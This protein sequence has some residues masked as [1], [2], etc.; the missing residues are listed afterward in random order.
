MTN[1]YKEDLNAKTTTFFPLI[2]FPYIS[3]EMVLELKKIAKEKRETARICLH[4]SSDSLLQFMLIFHPE[5]KKINI[6]KFLQQDSIYMLIEGEF[7]I[8]ML[9]ENLS[10]LQKI[11]FSQT[12]NQ[13]FFIPKNNFYKLEIISQELLLAEVRTGPFNYAN[14][15]IIKD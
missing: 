14:Q 15:I 2:N 1:V 5:R 9:D 7:S 10:V 13:L 3:T 12:S 4:E 11:N 8:S 6:Q